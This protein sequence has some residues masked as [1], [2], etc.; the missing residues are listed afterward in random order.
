[1]TNFSLNVDLK[2]YSSYLDY[3]PAP[4]GFHSTKIP[5]NIN[6]WRHFQGN[7]N[8][9]ISLEQYSSDEGMMQLVMDARVMEQITWNTKDLLRQI[10]QCSAK[11]PAV[12][13][14]Y[15]VILQGTVFLRRFQVGFSNVIEFER[16]CEALRLLGFPI[17]MAPVFHASQSHLQSITES[18]MSSQYSLEK[19]YSTPPDSQISGMSVTQNSQR[20]TPLYVYNKNDC[21]SQFAGV[22]N[23]SQSGKGL[24][25]QSFSQT[26]N[27]SMTQEMNE[28]DTRVARL[29]Q[30]EMWPD[31]ESKNSNF[32]E[33]SDTNSFNKSTGVE[34]PSASKQGKASGKLIT[35][36]FLNRSNQATFDNSDRTVSSQAPE[37]SIPSGVAVSISNNTLSSTNDSSELIEKFPICSNETFYEDSTRQ[38]EPSLVPV[39]GT[40]SNTRHQE[41]LISTK[42]LLTHPLEGL[43]QNRL[44]SVS[45][46]TEKSTSTKPRPI[47]SPHVINE[48]LK[49]A[50]FTSWVCSK[51]KPLLLIIILLTN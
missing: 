2:R 13:C 9:K 23:I 17:K 1:M 44:L 27:D 31:S 28:I 7:G 20:Q 42:A 21:Q 18:I 33:I 19:P 36:K 34:I 37:D 25:T 22:Y 10:A 51:K 15:L 49:D 29:Q 32:A 45:Q 30:T 46:Q 38:K 43:R 24:D 16:F 11:Y 4:Q 12:L 40:P 14:K 48:K 3:V 39:S 50:A 8:F 6:Q 35:D 26:M 5:T 47:I 41:D